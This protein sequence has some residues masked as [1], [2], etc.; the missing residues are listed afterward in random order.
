M[1][2]RGDMRDDPN[3]QTPDTPE[4]LREASADTGSD[5][6]IEP[7]TPDE[8]EPTTSGDESAPLNTEA[9]AQPETTG[10]SSASSA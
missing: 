8:V 9:S 1:R 6:H 4:Q 3:E 2:K 5:A 10:D 7:M